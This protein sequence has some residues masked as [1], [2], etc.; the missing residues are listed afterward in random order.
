MSS[1]SKAA[2]IQKFRPPPGSRGTPDTGSF[3]GKARYV[4]G[5]LVPSTD[6]SRYYKICFDCAQ[7]C[8]VC[9]CR[10]AISHG[11]CKHLTACGLKGRRYGKNIADAKKYGFLG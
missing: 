1:K 10:G 9:D 7:I 4:G 6:G 8:W 3:N 11:Q 2:N 5:F